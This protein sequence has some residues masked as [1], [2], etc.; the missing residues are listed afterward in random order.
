MRRR[1]TALD[2]TAALVILLLMVQ[3]WL[4]SATLDAYL[5]GHTDAAL[6][7]AVCSG[8]IFAAAAGLY[9]FVRRIDR[10]R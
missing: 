1:T 7:G 5:A 3:V 8:L 4:L 2:G 10:A 6:P 9:W